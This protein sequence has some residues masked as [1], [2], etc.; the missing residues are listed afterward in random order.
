VRTPADPLELSLSGF[1]A[2]YQQ[3]LPEQ[4]KR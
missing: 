1:D 3:A 4:K 2:M